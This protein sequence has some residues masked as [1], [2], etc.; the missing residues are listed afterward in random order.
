MSAAEP[1]H[2]LLG[3]LLVLTAAAR[4]CARQAR[5]PLPEARLEA[6]AAVIERLGRGLPAAPLP[7]GTTHLQRWRRFLASRRRGLDPHTIRHLCWQVD[8]ATDGRFHDCL[9]RQGV[10]LGACSLQGL[11]RAC[12]ARWS[13]ELAQGPVVTAVWR[14]VASYAGANRIVARWRAALPMILGLRGEEV[15]AQT[16]VAQRSPLASA[17]QEWGLEAASPYVQAAVRHA[18]RLCAAQMPH[19]GALTAY[20]FGELL[21]WPHWPPEALRAEV[22]ALLLHPQAPAVREALIGFVLR[23]PRLGDPRRPERAANWVGMAEAARR[24]VIQWLSRAAIE[25]PA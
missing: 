5:R 6:L 13:P 17:C 24:L 2:E 15:L 21:P 11:V 9:D 7:C 20:L 23:D 25:G 4:E 16:L 18:V 22:A 1:R 3:A 14:R 10:T 8:V 19:R 12:H